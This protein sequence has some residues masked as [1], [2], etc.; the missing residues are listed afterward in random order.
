MSPA[1]HSRDLLKLAGDIESNP[2]PPTCDHCCKPIR[3][4]TNPLQCGE[5]GCEQNCHRQQ[6]CSNISRWTQH[7][8]TWYCTIHN[9]TPE[10]Q[11]NGPESPKTPNTSQQ[12]TNSDHNNQQFQQEKQ[13]NTEQI[14]QTQQVNKCDTCNNTLKRN[15]T[16][17]KC[18]A[19]TCNNQ[20]HKQEKCSNI[21]RYSKVFEWQCSHHRQLDI[22]QEEH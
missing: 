22:Q 19:E 14:S 9:L 21:N 20:C 5:E 2:G 4:R 3:A 10:T 16:P 12:K 8:P 7:S 15:I 6:R 1:L 17:L 18:K 11:L 13:P